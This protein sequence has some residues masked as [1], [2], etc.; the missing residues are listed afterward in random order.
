MALA[1]DADSGSSARVPLLLGGGGP[2]VTQDGTTN[3]E[4]EIYDPITGEWKRYEM[5]QYQVRVRIV[6]SRAAIKKDL[7]KYFDYVVWNV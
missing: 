2:L 6:W 7:A 1:P 4:T 5:L 3:T